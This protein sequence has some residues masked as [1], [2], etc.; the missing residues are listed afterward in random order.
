MGVAG[1]GVGFIYDHDLEA[2]P[3]ILVD[4]LGLRYFFE[5]FLNDDAVIVTDVGRGDFEVVDGGD[6][7]EFEFAAGGGLE[8]A[9]VDFD[10][11]GAGAVEGAK[12]G[13]DAGL[14]AGA[15]RTVEE[16]VWEVGRGCLVSVSRCVCSIGVD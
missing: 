1:Q 16:K 2:L 8:D 4:L 10:L 9:G 6:D 7:V 3:G 15:G 14:L 13:E 12:G 11:F 5:E